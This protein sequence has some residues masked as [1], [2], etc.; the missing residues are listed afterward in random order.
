MTGITQKHVQDMARL[1]AAMNAASEDNFVTEAAEYSASPDTN[2]IPVSSV[3]TDTKMGDILAAFNRVTEGIIE[4]AD[5]QTELAKALVTETTDRGVKI[6]SWEI[7]VY[8]ADVGKAY[9]VI[10]T[11][12]GEP[13]VSDL[14]LYEAAHALVDMLND[15]KTFASES[16]RSLLNFEREYTKYLMDAVQH[17]NL[18]KNSE[19]A[20]RKMIAEHRYSESKR[21]ALMAKNSI[22]NM[23]R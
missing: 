20:S 2:N 10:H 17:A 5:T 13:I 9:N 8:S 19:N 7:E 16:V 18:A 11:M 22:K 4:T 14:R 6:G 3:V 1:V 23:L 12:T 15:G 21:Q